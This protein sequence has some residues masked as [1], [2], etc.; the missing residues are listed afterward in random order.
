MHVNSPAGSTLGLGTLATLRGQSV[1]PVRRY[2]EDALI[3]IDSP[4]PPRKLGTSPSKL[5]EDQEQVSLPVPP[6]EM[7]R[8]E[9]EGVL[10]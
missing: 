10:E 2:F 9:T 5:R 3:G 1:V 7:S 4:P 8:N 6:G